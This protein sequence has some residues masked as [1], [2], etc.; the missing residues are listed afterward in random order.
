[1]TTSAGPTRSTPIGTQLMAILRA[2][3]TAYLDPVVDTLV[4]NGIT[5]VEVTL[6]IPGAV[7]AIQRL[8]PRLP[9]SVSLGAGTVTT[10]RQAVTCVQAGASFLVS[11]GLIHQAVE[12]ALEHRLPCY[13][14]AWTCTEVLSAWHAGASAVKIFPA[15][16]AGPAHLRFLREPLPGIPFLVTG[17]CR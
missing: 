6:T 9:A 8:R 13:P 3:T 10:A 2:P 1:M 5:C 4:D 16:L 17:G 15:G 12:V 7:P 14:G 11:P